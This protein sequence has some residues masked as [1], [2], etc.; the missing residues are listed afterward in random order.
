MGNLLGP[1]RNEENNLDMIA[2]YDGSV[3][4]DISSA[5]YTP[6]TGFAIRAIQAHDISGG[7]NVKVDH[8]DLAQTTGIRTGVTLYLPAKDTLVDF[9]LDIKKVYK[10]G[11]AAATITGFITAIRQ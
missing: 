3:T 6:P 4:V 10:T 11:T 1:K 9:G 5:D 7:G 2:G 8:Y